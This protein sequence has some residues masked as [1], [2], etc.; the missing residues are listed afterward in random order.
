MKDIILITS[1]IR[2]PDKPLSYTNI[3]SVFTA[4][5]RFEQTKKTIESVK[6][7][8]P[9]GIICM[10]ECSQLLKD[11]LHY[12]CH[13]VDIFINIMD[14]C[15]QE[16]IDRVYSHSK[17][18][19][20]GTQTIFALQYLLDNNIEYKNFFKLS[21]R[22]WISDIFNYDNFN[23]EEI[24]INYMN[25]DPNICLTVLYKLPNKQIVNDFLCFLIANINEME[26]CIGYECLVARFMHKYPHK[27]IQ[28]IG[29]SG[30]V[31]IDNHFYSG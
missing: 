4:N 19:G 16:L 26:Q 3:R 31:S 27:Q 6:Q 1:V 7:N 18:L 29:I 2:P 12:L 22:Y 9:N 23:N 17:S 8:I 15:N 14:T 13:N 10:V 11:E 24:V 21:G 28:P 5:E 25:Q 30:Y 20:E